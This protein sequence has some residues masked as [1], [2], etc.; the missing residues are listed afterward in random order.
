MLHGAPTAQHTSHTSLERD[1]Q[2]TMSKSHQHPGVSAAQ[3]GLTDEAAHGPPFPTKAHDV[4]QPSLKHSPCSLWGKHTGMC[5]SV[6]GPG[7]AKRTVCLSLRSPWS[8]R[9]LR[10]VGV[11]ITRV[12][13][14]NTRSQQHKMVFQWGPGDGNT[15]PKSSRAI[16]RNNIERGKQ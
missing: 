15:Q 8:R 9:K 12:V 14:N 7:G 3:S 10:P 6:Q 16:L 11:T 13:N 2:G 1:T 4:L 5:Y